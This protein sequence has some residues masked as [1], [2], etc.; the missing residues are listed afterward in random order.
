[1]THPASTRSGRPP[2]TCDAHTGSP[3]TYGRVWPPFRERRSRSGPAHR[4][5][6]TWGCGTASCGHHVCH[7][8]TLH[9]EAKQLDRTQNEAPDN[10]FFV[11]ARA[12]GIARATVVSLTSKTR[13]A[14]D[15]VPDGL[16]CCSPAQ[17][18]HRSGDDAILASEGT[19]G[20]QTLEMRLTWWRARPVESSLQLCDRRGS[21]GSGLGPNPQH[22]PL[23]I[24]SPK[25]R[26]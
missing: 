24:P 21:H 6:R 3:R 10:Q 1:M 4:R 20:N 19:G 22:R 25:G 18:R 7:L 8:A 23:V 12:G 14:R 13:V 17:V 16:R 11:I 26:R 2:G 15:S 9:A 5:Y